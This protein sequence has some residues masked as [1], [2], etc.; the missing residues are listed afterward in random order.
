MMIHAN[1]WIGIGLITVTTVGYIAAA[2][3][4]V[5]RNDKKSQTNI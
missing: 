3:F 1:F 4:S 2:W 5:K